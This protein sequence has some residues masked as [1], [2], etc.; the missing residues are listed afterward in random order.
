[1]GKGYDPRDAFYRKA[2]QNQLRAR[3]AFKIEEIVARFR[4]VRPGDVVVDLGAAPG[5]FLQILA[6]VVGPR[7]FVLGVDVAAIRP[8]G[9]V[10]QTL[11]RDVFAPDLLADLRAR[12][13]GPADVVASDLA[14][15]TTGIRDRDEARSLALAGVALELAGT[16]LRPG[17]Q[18]VCKVFMGG[19]F[20]AFY[21][22]V[23]TRFS[24]ASIVRPEA[25]RARSREVY[26][27]G[28]E[29]RS[30]PAGVHDPR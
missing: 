10:V 29:H 7:G 14:P 21:A 23:R 20:E 13:P 16:L 27:V 5:G 9:G 2:K 18:F 6:E 19:D 22:D 11:Q 24:A 3:S 12:L 30:T 25:T 26:V 28:R 4:L 1:M 15:K 8:L 17:G